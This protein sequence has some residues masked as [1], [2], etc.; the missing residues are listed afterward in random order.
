MTLAD[1]QKEFAG[2]FVAMG[3]P[4]I[5]AAAI[6]G[7][8]G[9]QEN[10]CLPTTAGAKDHGSDGSL[11]WRGTRLTELQ[12]MPAWDTLKTQ[13]AFTIRELQ[14]DYK[15]LEADLRAGVKSGATEEEVKHRLA[16]LTLNFC[17]VFE[18]PSADGRMPERRISFAEQT[19]ALISPASAP[20]IVAEK[21]NMPAPPLLGGEF[22]AA[23]RVQTPAPRAPIGASTMPPLDP[24]LVAQLIAILAPV[25]ESLISGLVKGLISQLAGSSLPGGIVGLP[26]LP[27]PPAQLAQLIA[28][29]IAKLAPQ[30]PK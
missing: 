25:A 19:L 4:P 13:A 15:S 14:R 6:A 9:T 2:Y 21:I 5:S 22:P 11:Q 20:S 24:A 29:E 12:A 23:F 7:G 8:N 28:A 30:V 27:I 10:S 1:R 16:S 26:A 17:D 18:R 3:Y